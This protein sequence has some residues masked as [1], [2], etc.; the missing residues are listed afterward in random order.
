MGVSRDYP[1]FWITGTPIILR[2]D[3][4]TNFNFCMHNHTLWDQSEQKPINNFVKSSRGR[5]LGLSKIFRAPK[6]CESCGHLR[7]SS[8]FLLTT[9]Y[10]Y[11]KPL[12]TY[13]VIYNALYSCTARCKSVTN[14]CNYC[15]T[16]CRLQPW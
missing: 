2:T 13:R 7:G 6:S 10:V 1:N 5:T 4:A 9:R 12:W 16:C 11:G 8:A 15:T 14:R 3:E